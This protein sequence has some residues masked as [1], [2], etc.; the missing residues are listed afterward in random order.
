MNNIVYYVLFSVMLAISKLPSWIHY[1]NSSVMAFV[2]Y[3]VV[4][5]RRSIVEKNIKESFPNLS[6]QEQNELKKK[7]YSH[8]CDIFVE[9]VMYLGMS[10]GEIKRRMRFSSMDAVRND[11]IK[12]R[13]IALYLGHYAN[14]E[15]VSSL[16]LHLGDV[17]TTS[18]IYHPM[19]NPLF[20]RLIGYTRSRF[21]SK[22]IPIDGSIRHIL[23][24]ARQEKPIMVG[25]ISD[26]T[27]RWNN[28]HLWIPFLGHAETPVFTGAERIAKRLDMA[29]Y[30]LDVRKVKRGYYLAEFI[31][32]TSRPRESTD[33]ELTKMY[34]RMLEETI[35]RNPSLWLWSH[36]R[37]KRTKKVWEKRY[38]EI[39]TNKHITTM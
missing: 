3:H 7:F 15:W 16:S 39:Q 37:W 23:K 8:L 10:E 14:W 24:Y 5:Y 9:S 33:F 4:R 2:L 35:R 17:C 25:F 1:F 13:S 36:N 6:P 21:G 27:P 32:M 18:Q 31:P 34:S 12:G 28:I 22:N 19:E 38:G 20:D 29:V 11:C 26:Q 30:Y